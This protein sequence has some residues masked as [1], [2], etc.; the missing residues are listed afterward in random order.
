[1]ILIMNKNFNIKV[2]VLQGDFLQT[3]P[4]LQKKKKKEKEKKS[5][6]SVQTFLQSLYTPM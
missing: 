1:M 6:L 5:Q 4:P 3:P 2:L